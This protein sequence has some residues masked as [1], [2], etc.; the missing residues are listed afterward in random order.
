MTVGA[1]VA[2]CGRFCG[3]AARPG[4]EVEDHGGA[5]AAHEPAGLPRSLAKRF[6]QEVRS[7][8]GA[9]GTRELLGLPGL[10]RALAQAARLQVDQPGA[11]VVAE[12]RGGL[13]APLARGRV[14][15]RDRV[16]L[17]VGGG[18]LLEL[19]GRLGALAQAAWLQAKQRG[20]SVV[21]PGTV[22]VPAALAQRPTE[23][24]APR[25]SP[26]PRGGLTGRG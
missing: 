1:A 10:L 6:I 16:R 25:P 18:E 26:R 12:G 14:Q 9:G 8:L 11:A 20:G 24:L 19:P 5:I 2:G 15:E 21:G 22:G 4:L 23:P 7:G 13:A 17:A 3:S